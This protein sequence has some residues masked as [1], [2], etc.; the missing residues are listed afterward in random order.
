[1]GGVDLKVNSIQDQT[2][3]LIDFFAGTLL[4]RSFIIALSGGMNMGHP[5]VNYG[6]LG[7]LGQYTYQ[8]KS[9]LHFSGQVLIASGSTK[10]YEREKT[11]TMDNFGNITGAGFWLIEPALN[12]E[13]N[14][15]S[16]TRLILGLGYRYVIGLDEDHESISTTK[17][18]NEDLSGVNLIFGVKIASY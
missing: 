16:K 15:S 10:D 4:N 18:T 7:I 5:S 13:L 3:T 6:Y 8:P 1:M 12:A 17:V 9:L 2:G 14:L 11:S